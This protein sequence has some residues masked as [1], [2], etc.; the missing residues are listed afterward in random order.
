VHGGAQGLGLFHLASRGKEAIGWALDRAAMT[1]SW[2]TW[3]LRTFVSARNTTSTV[4]SSKHNL[5]RGLS[6]SH[7]CLVE[8]FDGAGEGG[9][10]PVIADDDGRVGRSLLGWV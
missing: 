7:K 4:E 10:L 3:W 2:E 1:S 5:V 8:A 9:G 6:G